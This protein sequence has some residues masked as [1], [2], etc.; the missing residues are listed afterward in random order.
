MFEFKLKTINKFLLTVFILTTLLVPVLFLNKLIFLILLSL[1]FF[2]VSLK[3]HLITVSPFIVILIFLF[4]FL[5]SFLSNVNRGL[6][7]QLLNSV[8]LL[9]LIYPIGKYKI[10]LDGIIKLSG[11]FMAVS[12]GVF[13][14]IFFMGFGAP[15]E[16][17]FLEV[18]KE[19]CLG[20]FGGRYFGDEITF[21]FHLGSAPFL[22]LPFSLYCISFFKE[23][24]LS[25]FFALII[26]MTTIIS[27][28]SRGL[29]F[30][31][32]LSLIVI[33][34]QNLK[35]SSKI[36]FTLSITTFIF[37]VFQYLIFNTTVFSPEES[38]NNVKIGHFKSF[39]YNLNLKNFIL[40]DGLA[41]YYFTI[42]YGGLKA[43][44]ELTPFDMFRYFGFI[45]TIILY[46]VIIF[47]TNEKACYDNENRVYLMIFLIY[48][49]LSFTNPV[50]FNSFG[51]F[52]VLW[53]WSKILANKRTRT[54]DKI[55][56]LN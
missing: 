28:S 55:K 13:Y 37:F 50:F 34:F 46:F 2:K 26:I 17:F 22:F 44:T 31:S 52:V 56:Y 23:K 33:W 19:Y 8:T 47:P 18:F 21:M 11:I 40:G 10:N 51:L 25:S 14:L 20:A 45:L 30:A 27:S 3:S 42:G 16:L 15:Y 49:G 12:T 29:L 39:V 1:V 36:I 24:K 9:L 53:Y 43:E 48:V 7:F 5:T 32:I 38:S 4:G 35:F 54:I 6:S 41:S